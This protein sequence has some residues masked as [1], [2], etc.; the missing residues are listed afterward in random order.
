MLHMIYALESLKHDGKVVLTGCW[1]NELRPLLF[2]RPIFFLCSL[3]EIHPSPM[4]GGR[5]TQV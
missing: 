1:I 2:N 5:E 3:M 4:T